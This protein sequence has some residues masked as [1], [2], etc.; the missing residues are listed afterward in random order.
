[1]RQRGYRHSL[2]TREV[3]SSQGSAGKKSDVVESNVPEKE[4][5]RREAAA[6]EEYETFMRDKWGSM[7]KAEQLKLRRGV[8][9]V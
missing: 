6:K 3:F 8:N 4:Q 5:K 9:L 2:P 7:S 1:M